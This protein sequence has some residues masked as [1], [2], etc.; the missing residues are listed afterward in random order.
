MPLK[1][2]FLHGL[3]GSPDDI[4]KT[5]S[6]MPE[7]SHFAPRVPY[8]DER[9]STLGEV[10]GAVLQTI[11]PE[12]R[13]EDTILAGNSLGGS[14]A[15][16]MGASFHRIFLVSTH[17]RTTSRRIGRSMSTLHT[18]LKRIFHD[19]GV[20]SPDQVSAY[21]AM[22]KEFTSCRKRFRRLRQLK[23]MAEKF[24]L[25]SH[26]RDQDEKITLICGRHDQ[27]SP[28]PDFKE[29]VTHYPGVKLHVIDDC[30]HAI[31]LEKPGALASILLR[32]A[33]QQG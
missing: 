23:R 29:L 10:A 1:L 26:I 18:E 20:L 7:C 8:F 14:L 4:R 28:L 2:V 12:F 21:E 22:W 13:K 3:A 9:Y 33:A 25:H 6:H 24:D 11:P 32:E 30:G 17:L 31:P 19:P 5:L 27:L 16:A 15:M